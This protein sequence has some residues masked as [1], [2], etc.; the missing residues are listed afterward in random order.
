MVALRP[1]Q[2]D[3]IVAVERELASLR[4]T[5]IVMATGTGKTV[6]FAE[7]ARRFVATG[8]RALI[9][10]HRGELLDQAAAKL[11]DLGLR[12][13]I[14]RAG[15]VASTNA[16]VV[17]GSVQTL[18]GKRL[19]R[20][21]PDAFGMIVID[22]CF[23][24][25][26]TIDGRPIESIRVG[27]LVSSF[28][29]RSIVKR[30]VR[31]LF[32]SRPNAMV[33]IT[34][35]GRVV[36]ATA[37]HPFLTSD[38][39]IPA[40]D[41][42]GRRVG[43]CAWMVDRGSDRHE[44][45]QK[46]RLSELLQ[47]RHRRADAEDRDRSGWSQPWPD[48]SQET[49]S[50]KGEAS[51][52]AWVDRV[53]VLQPTGDGTFG[54]VCP[55]GF[56]YNFEVEETHTYV[57]NGFIVHNCHHAPA[58]S[59]RR[60]VDR[61][62][63]AK[64][65]GVT[66]TPDRGDG[67]AMGKVFESVAFRYELRGAIGDGWLAPIVA[68]RIN[69]EGI[70]LRRVRM[71]HGDLDQSELSAAMTD[72]RAL[73]EVV[74]P[75]VEQAGDRLTIVFGVDVAHAHRLAEVI[76]RHRPR[77]AM[78]VDGS[79]KP[80]ERAAALAM[81]ADGRVRFL[82]NCAL[83]TEGFDEPSIA[84]VAVA[85]PTM[86]RALY[87]QMI[88]RGTRKHP[89]KAD[90]L[91]LDFVGNSRHRLAG[92]EDALA[93]RDLTEAEKRA[94]AEMMADEQREL[95]AVLDH[96]ADEARNVL[97]RRK[98]ALL[99]HYRATEIDPY[100]GRLSVPDSPWA[101]EPASSSQIDAIERAGLARPPEGL[102]KGE[103]SAILGGIQAQRQLGSATVPQRRLLAKFKLDV[104]G[105]TF[106]RANELIAALKRGSWKPWSIQHEP[107]FSRRKAVP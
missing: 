62:P 92:P 5:M 100:L 75:L 76:N 4:S 26:T 91:V 34:I 1:Y 8:G 63:S 55:D 89:G 48:P 36:H 35:A 53:E 32:V 64:V 20:H 57:A 37:G 27:D 47:D 59:Y 13:S 21:A 97:S 46:L 56:V 73:H 16:P 69:V 90:C 74:A 28:D 104:G 31:R 106:D 7:F 86:S 24:A 98:I 58:A 99:V 22:E 96:A 6:V 2:S 80:A 85:R 11:R 30:P 77:S 68:R 87:C 78:A 23:P 61:F 88:G 65:L 18:R 19:E 105:M 15:D 102:T 12:A 45:A 39:W 84:C 33:R 79:A 67:G 107:E 3:A 95:G 9:V 29:G 83:F 10:A 17:I 54:G 70:D 44:D 42:H 43:V 50:Q 40:I 72:E 93:G 38:G 14:D 49:G 60:I 94:A 81:F 101:R 82:V 103:A 25:G 52:W 71:H 51:R 41:L 66:A